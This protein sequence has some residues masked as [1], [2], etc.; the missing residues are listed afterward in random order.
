MVLT[1][2]G[3]PWMSIDWRGVMIELVGL[4]AMLTS[5][6]CPVLMPPNTPPALLL[7]K[8]CGVIESPCVVPRC[9]TL[10]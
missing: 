1:S 10:A 9:V 4:I 5:R 8:P 2:A 7:T 3:W 6:S